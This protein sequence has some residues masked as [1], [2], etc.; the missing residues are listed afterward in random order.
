LEAASVFP[1][2]N[3]RPE[4]A[5]SEASLDL[6][7]IIHFTRWQEQCDIQL[8][9]TTGELSLKTSYA[10]A[11]ADSAAEKRIPFD[12]LGTHLCISTHPGLI[13]PSRRLR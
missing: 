2:D 4:V 9:S 10:A 8:K 3:K 13:I 6:K 5:S 11:A 7:G 1:H 12:F